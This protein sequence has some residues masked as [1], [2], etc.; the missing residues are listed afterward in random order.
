MKSKKKLDLKTPFFMEKWP[1]QKVRAH[2]APCTN[3]VNTNSALFLL[4]WKNFS[5]SHLASR[6]EKKGSCRPPREEKEF[7]SRN[8]LKIEKQL[9]FTLKFISTS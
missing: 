9:I 5:R 1:S 7:M 8:G 6:H 4:D 3:K 2:L